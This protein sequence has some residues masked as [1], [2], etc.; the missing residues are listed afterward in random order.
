MDAMSSLTEGGE[1]DG[2]AR[3][4]HSLRNHNTDYW[5]NMYPTYSLTDLLPLSLVPIASAIDTDDIP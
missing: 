5:S 3:L 4:S 1:W 2:L